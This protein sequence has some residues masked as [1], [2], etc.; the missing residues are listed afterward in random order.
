MKSFTVVKTDKN[1]LWY[2]LRSLLYSICTTA[3]FSYIGA[4]VM[5]AM[6]IK[7]DSAKYITVIICMFSAAIVSFLSCKGWK[8]RGAL[9]GIISVTPLI[10]YSLFNLLFKNNT[11]SLFFI[12]LVLIVLIGGIMGMLRIKIN[13]KFRVK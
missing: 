5:Y 7:L 12:K 9:L 13:K 2:I 4:K 10:L 11:V 3:F 8:S 1:M 6:D